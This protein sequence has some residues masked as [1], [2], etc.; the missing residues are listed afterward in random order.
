MYRIQWRRP[1]LDSM[2]AVVRAHPDRKQE[3]AT[4]LRSLA[5]GLSENPVE[6]GEGREPPY[7]VGFFGPLTVNF[8]PEPVEQVV[9]VTEVHLHRDE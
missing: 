9:Y 8:R 2:A 4:T 1:A 5:R 7:R 6:V 3:F